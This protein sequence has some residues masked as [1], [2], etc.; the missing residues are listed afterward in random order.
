MEVN[1]ILNVLIKVTTLR[2]AL[3]GNRN[4]IFKSTGRNKY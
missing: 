3:D 4:N 2:L 1:G